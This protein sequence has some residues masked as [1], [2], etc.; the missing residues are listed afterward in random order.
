MEWV[1]N[2]SQ[3]PALC[4]LSLRT[5]VKLFFLYFGCFDF[6][7][8]LGFLNCDD[9]CL[10]QGGWGGFMLVCCESGFSVLMAGSGIYVLY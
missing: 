8:E 3:P 4:K 10:G 5:V 1:D 2:N 7:G 6:R 9:I